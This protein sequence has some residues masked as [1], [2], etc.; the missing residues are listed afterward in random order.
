MMKRLF[1][2]AFFLGVLLLPALAPSAPQAPPGPVADLVLRNGKIWTGCKDRPEAEALAVQGTRIVAVGTN[3]EVQRLAGAR[4]RTL[5]LHGRRVVPGFYDSHVHLL[6][7]GLRLAEVA[8]KDAADEAEFGRRLREFDQKLPRDRWLVGGEW[9]HDRT[10][11]GTLPTAELLDKYVPDRAVFLRRYDGHMGVVDSR[12]LK[13]AGITEKTPDPA[14]GVIYRRLGSQ[15][16][17]GVLRDNAMDLV[18]RLIP[19]PSEQEIVEAVR[20]A[21]AEARSV[22]VTSMQDMDGSDAATRM[23]LY[24]LYQQLARSGDLTARID[25][26]WPLSAWKELLQLAAKVG[27]DD[28]WVKVGGVKGFVDGSLGSSTGKMYEPY[29]NEPSSTGVYVTPL[30]ALHQQIRDADRAGLSVAVHAIGDRANAELLDIFAEV[31]KENGPRDRRFRV[32][33]AQHLRP[34]DYRRF[35]ELGVIASMQPYHA[36]DDG[37]WAEGRIGPRRCASSYACRS[38]LDAGAQLAFGSDWSVAPLNPLLGIDAAVTRRTLDGKHPGGWFPEQKIGVAEAIKA[39]TLTSAYAA[40]EEKDRGSLEPGK[41]ADLAVLSRDILAPSERDHIAQTQ[42]LL[43]MVGGKVVLARDDEKKDNES[44]EKALEWQPAKGPLAT[45]WAKDV[46]PEKVLPEYPRPQMVRKDW[47]N[48]NGL[49]QLAEAKEGEEP[50]LGKKLEQRILVPFPV[51]SALSGVMKHA[52]RLWYRRTFTLPKNWKGKQF[53]LHFGAVDWEATVWVNG[54]RLGQH[55]GGYDGFTFD[56]SGALKDSG[57]QEIIVGVYD[58]TDRGTQPRG[59]QVLK[60][61]GIFYTPT[62]GIWQTVWLEPVPVASRIE[63]LKIEPDVDHSKVRITVLGRVKGSY[64]LDVTV[65][66]PNHPPHVFVGHGKLGVPIE[67]P[68]DELVLWSPEHPELYVFGA[69][70]TSLEVD[71]YGDSVRSYFGM[72]RISVG[73]DDKGITRLLLNGKPYFMVG[74]L[75]QGFW[76]DGIYTAP[77]DEALKYDIEI[78]KKLGFNMTRKHVK[79]EPERWYYWCDK[80]GLL[81]WQDMPSGDRSIGSDQPDI[82]RTPES[83]KEYEKELRAMIE[84]RYNHPSIVMWV[85]FNEGWGQFDTARITKLTRELDPSRLVNSASGW[86]DRGVGDMHDMHSYPGPGS[87]NPEEKRAAVLG[88]FGGLGLGI[89][90]HSWSSKTWGYLGTKDRADLTRRYERLLERVWQLKDKPGLSAAVY[91]Q[92]TDVEEE[93]NGLLTY[94]RAMIKV[95]LERAAAVNR[96]DT[97]RIPQLKE[98]VPTSKEN[99]IVWRYTIEKPGDD[100][101]KPSF[102]D[103]SWKKGPGGFGTPRTPGAVV[104]TLW[105]TDD[106]WLRRDF[107]LPDELPKELYL[108]LHH[109]D[110]AEV[111]LNGVLAAKVA[112]YTTDYGEVP[113]SDEARAALKPGK[114][115]FAVHCHQTTG[116]QYIDVGLLTIQERMR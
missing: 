104:R 16:P 51:E 93:G 82:V 37:R 42:V 108:N 6:G 43:T 88:E 79:V 115:Q 114:N 83:V 111:Y 71:E 7:S 49:W 14:G 50:P 113:I 109:D 53:L 23:K 34:A 106:V 22:G 76:P 38:L 68:L 87:F 101:F 107:T 99:G 60:P 73:K 80:L 30:D 91:T 84:G 112:G 89:K 74:P 3:V 59:K 67:V 110:D 57:E 13:L 24:R 75:D 56:V 55:R 9:D 66:S 46:M 90:G 97:S 10:F 72:R 44:G 31:A 35:Q 100:W 26:R 52:E 65:T 98:V 39:F 96:G 94:D 48:L 86:T 36:I 77:T 41:L 11:H 12:V 78:T 105:K 8:L 21:L 4:T 1:A 45:R 47:L 69:E 70:L 85:V 62:T 61:G 92:I 25:L 103:A 5:D 64:M 40:F 32:E 20:A 29:L 18:T 33:H 19:V 28:D 54:K 2:L 116:G 17:S 27:Q 63:G 81:V 58:P 102:D 95:D 15:E